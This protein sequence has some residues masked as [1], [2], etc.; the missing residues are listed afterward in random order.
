MAFRANAL[1]IAFL[2]SACT[3]PMMKDEPDEALLRALPTATS[4][5]TQSAKTDVAPRTRSVFDSDEVSFELNED[6]WKKI[7]DQE[8][9]QAYQRR[10]DGKN[11]YGDIVAFR[12]ETIIPAKLV[13]IATILN[14]PGL[15]K[16]W[17]DALQ[18]AH[19]VE[20]ISKFESVNYNKTDVPWPFQ[21]RDFVY[22][23]NVQV[24]TDPPVM[25]IKM[26]SEPNAKEPEH[27]GVVRG[28][29]LNSY[30]Y[31][32]ELPESQGTKMVIE[33]AVDPKGAIPLWLVN[34][35]QKRWPHNTL[36][37]LRKLATDASIPVSKDIEEFFIKKR[38]Q[39]APKKGGKKK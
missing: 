8:G 33:A 25:L 9:I 20:Q 35:S 14:T 31:M 3:H 15:Q 36:L 28:A 24:Q 19:I 1:I 23:V 10:D 26:K 12:G 22:R 5:E 30:F 37:K 39:S 11:P 18:D 16:E 27:D 21:D 2:I 13:K 34:A 7:S 17:V 29:I 32:K 38:V 6:D 4:A